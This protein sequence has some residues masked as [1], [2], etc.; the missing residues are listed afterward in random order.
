MP[1][2][3]PVVFVLMLL[4]GMD[5]ALADAGDPRGLWRIVDDRTGRPRAEIRLDLRDGI[6]EGRLVRSLR[7][8]DDPA[9]R[10]TRCPGERL[11]LPLRDLAILT[12]LRRVSDDPLRW[13]GGEL[14]DP[15][16]GVVYRARLTLAPSNRQLALRAYLGVALLGRTQTWQRVEAARQGACGRAAQRGG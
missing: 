7:E 16:E 8:G 3:P 14:L 13:E 9:A 12:G 6:L 4:M 15:D 10:C 1:V 2:L 5:C 11:N